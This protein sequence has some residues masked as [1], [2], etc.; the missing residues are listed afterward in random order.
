M[1]FSKLFTAFIIAFLLVVFVPMII[2]LVTVFINTRGQVQDSSYSSKKIPN[3]YLQ[4]LKLPDSCCKSPN[5]NI[6]LDHTTISKL[7]N[8]ISYFFVANKYYLQIYKMD[9]S[10]RYSLKDS[11]KEG[12]SDAHSW[13]YSPYA[14][15]NETDMEFLYKNT[16]PK[17]PKTIFL[18]LHGDSTMTL[19]KNDT[20]AYYYCKCR[21]FWIRFN[22]D[23][24]NDIYGNL[25]NENHNEVHLELL[26]LKRN[27]KLFMLIL[28]SKYD[29]IYLRQKTLY[30]LLFK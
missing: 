17:K 12:F 8:P 9:D 5:E 26:I 11:I 22:A 14:V 2:G 1:K 24:P 21:N 3:D 4:I 25:K 18:D 6:V 16:K 27:K 15:D 23:D 28:S 29:G 13:Q 19:V 10:F 7:R 30:N 20:I